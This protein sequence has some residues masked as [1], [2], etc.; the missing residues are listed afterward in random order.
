M[1]LLAVCASQVGEILHIRSLPKILLTWQQIGWRLQERD[2]AGNSWALQEGH[3]IHCTI[4][5]KI[6]APIP[7]S[8]YI[9]P[10]TELL[11][12]ELF[13]DTFFAI[14][15]LIWRIFRNYY[16]KPH[17]AEIHIVEIRMHFDLLHGCVNRQERVWEWLY[18]IWQL[19]GENR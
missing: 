1:S 17:D 6:I 16:T 9:S 13:V 19:R 2:K 15:I 18:H 8:S 7:L 3:D 4:L 5:I 12:G 14:F 11:S 10:L